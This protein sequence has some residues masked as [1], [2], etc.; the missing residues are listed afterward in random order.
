MSNLSFIQPFL[1]RLYLDHDIISILDNIDQ[2]FKK[3]ISKV[4]NTLKMIWK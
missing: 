2:K 4:L 1:H 3:N